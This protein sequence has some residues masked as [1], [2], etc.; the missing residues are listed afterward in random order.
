MNLRPAACCFGI[1]VALAAC[2]G[3]G[4][5]TPGVNPGGPPEPGPT[6]SASIVTNQTTVTPS[7]STVTAS[8]GVPLAQGTMLA[9]LSIPALASGSGALTFTIATSNPSDLPDRAALRTRRALANGDAWVFLTITTGADAP[10]L[11]GPVGVTFAS[12][13]IS[14]GEQFSLGYLPPNGS[15]WQ[16]PATGFTSTASA[17]A[18]GV[19]FTL[20]SSGTFSA[21]ST[22]TFVLYSTTAAAPTPSSVPTAADGA[23][24]T[25][26]VA[27][28]YTATTAPETPALTVPSGLTIQT[29]ANVS[30]ARELAALP[31]GDL[32]VGTGGNQVYIIPNAEAS[33]GPAEPQVF[34]TVDESPPAG[35]PAAGDNHA[36]GVAFS[37][38]TCTIFV[39][40]E[41]HI[42]STPYKDGDLQ[43]ENLQE[44]AT[45]RTGPTASPGDGDVHTSTSVAVSG[46]TLYASMGSSCNGCTGETDPQRAAIWSMT[47]G[48]GNMTRVAENIRNAITLAVDPA[49][50]HLWAGGAGQDDLTE[51][52]PYEYMDDVT[53]SIAASGDGIANYGWPYCEENHVE[54]NTPPPSWPNGCAGT[55]EPLVEFPAYITHIGAAFYPVNQSGTYAFPSQYRGS[56]IVASHGSWHQYGAGN[57]YVSPPEVDDVPMN[58]DTPKTAMTNWGVDDP[59]S[60][61]TNLVTGFEPDNCANRIGR[62]T[63]VAV[64]SQGSVFIGD[65]Q[66]GVVYRIRP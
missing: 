55:V 50:G 64:G 66:A 10:A 39:A 52:H 35:E 27:S 26:A 15:A 63:G 60:Q 46:S 42:W 59:A 31:N 56:L 54:Y 24:C 43:A 9:D 38:P 41:Y 19:T 53:A 57:C 44:I 58:G 28:K 4:T 62:P 25:G 32:L 6:S 13:A 49:T 30:G 33:A 22:Y 16:E 21:N 23:N 2:G 12:S 18:G 29:I 48:G 8:V 37:G 20:G 61:Y 17:A 34:A 5:T 36:E 40:T 51:Y 11:S 1:L 45:V 14:A 47:L 7:G 65:D 3:G